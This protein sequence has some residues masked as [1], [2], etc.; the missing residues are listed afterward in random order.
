[1]I[2]AIVFDLD[3]TL[4]DRHGTLRAIVP[5][6]RAR[7]AVDPAL[8]DEQI[9]EYWIYGDD[10]YVYYGWNYIFAY[11][12]EHG[13]FTDPPEYGDYR[14]FIFENFAKVAVKLED[15]LPMLERLKKEGYKVGLIT[16][17]GHALQY[18]KLDL[19]GLRY[20]FDEIIVS[21][22]VLI[23]K[24]D[25]EIFL[26]MCEK[27]GVEPGECVY[28]GDN[29][30]NDV[31]GA[32]KAGYHTIWVKSTGT[33]MPEAPDPDESVE[34]IRDVPEKVRAIEKKTDKA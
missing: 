33:W 6:L 18:K 5:A 26:M 13:V 16:N 4:F 30:K 8:T 17:G 23:D 14:T 11:L 2:K 22:D 12:C 25:K 3:H 28:V 1:M 29:P 21:G 31:G 20:V 24:P 32:K 10:H 7:F 27:L 15:S 34:F 19:T 9:A